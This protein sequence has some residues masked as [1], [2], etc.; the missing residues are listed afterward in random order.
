VL[1]SK[2]LDVEAAGGA[3]GQ[4]PPRELAF[5]LR[6]PALFQAFFRYVASSISVNAHYVLKLYD[7]QEMQQLEQL[8]VTLS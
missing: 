4:E 1:H 3:P 7:M 5:C 8:V 2:K 6:T